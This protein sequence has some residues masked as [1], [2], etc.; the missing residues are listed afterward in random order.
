MQHRAQGVVGVTLVTLLCVIPLGCNWGQTAKESEQ[1]PA[2]LRVLNNTAK[3][4]FA[5]HVAPGQFHDLGLAVTEAIKN[6]DSLATDL[7][8][9]AASE[10][11]YGK[12][13]ASAMCTGLGELADNE[14]DSAPPP[15]QE[16]W[17]T[18]LVAQ[19]HVL[20]PNNLLALVQAKVNQFLAT[21]D[22][23]LIDPRLA[24]TYYQEC[25]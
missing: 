2:V 14:N 6:G 7:N 24:A 20:L 22:L 25:L 11:P 5:T 13:L 21:A 1:L 23:A 8:K 16:D 3:F 19:I 15:S 10:D 17:R 18:F 12:A 4:T 9:I